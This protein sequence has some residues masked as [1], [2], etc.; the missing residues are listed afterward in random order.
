MR[1]LCLAHTRSACV[2]LESV[3]VPELG[4]IKKLDKKGNGRI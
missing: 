3:D 1:I 2:L 4:D